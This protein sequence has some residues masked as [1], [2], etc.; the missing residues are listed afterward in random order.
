MA[1]GRAEGASLFSIS[2]SLVPLHGRLSLSLSSLSAFLFSLLSNLFSSN[3]YLP[4]DILPAY[5][6]QD[7]AENSL[8]F[9]FLY[10]FSRRRICE[11]YSLHAHTAWLWCLCGLGWH[12]CSMPGCRQHGDMGGH[13]LASLPAG[14]LLR[15]SCGCDL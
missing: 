12:C 13:G 2:F 5:N 4:H 10:L 15:G 9:L 7:S 6:K 8:W 14:I 3:F 11:L 1:G